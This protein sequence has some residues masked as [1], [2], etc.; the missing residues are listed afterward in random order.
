M[1]V[2][3]SPYFIGLFAVS[4]KHVR[5]C[6]ARSLRAAARRI[7]VTLTKMAREADAPNTHF[8]KR[9]TVFFIAL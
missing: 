8:V 5:Q 3:R 2:A 1:I 9:Y 6:A 7:A 4:L